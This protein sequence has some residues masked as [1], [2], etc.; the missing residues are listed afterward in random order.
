MRTK[1]QVLTRVAGKA[2]VEKRGAAA[3]W[4][5]LLRLAIEE[6]K[7]GGQFLLPGIG[8][9]AL[10]RRKARKGRNPQTGESM[11]IPPKTTLRFRFLKAFKEAVLPREPAISSA[12]T[13]RRRKAA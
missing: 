6:T 13:K 4:D 12:K 9:I 8:K 3:M 2:G 7:M 5:L 1:A 11:M 10:D